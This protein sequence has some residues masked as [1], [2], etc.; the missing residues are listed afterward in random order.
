MG[1]DQISILDHNLT[2]ID[3]EALTLQKKLEG[4]KNNA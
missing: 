1:K 2:K 4:S 3:V